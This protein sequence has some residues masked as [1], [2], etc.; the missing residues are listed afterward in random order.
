[1]NKIKKICKNC[2]YYNPKATNTYKCYTSDCPAYK[3]G[4][5]IGEEGE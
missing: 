2:S 3:N 4:I 1:M 5:L